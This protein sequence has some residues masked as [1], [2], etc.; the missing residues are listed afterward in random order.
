MAFAAQKFAPPL[1]MLAMAWSMVRSGDRASAN[2]FELQAG[3]ERGGYQRQPL[4]PLRVGIRN[5]AS[6]KR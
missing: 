1:Y 6:L 5:L 3:L 4:V 2:H